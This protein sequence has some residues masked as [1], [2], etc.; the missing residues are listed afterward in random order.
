MAGRNTVFKNWP[1]MRRTVWSTTSGWLLVGLHLCLTFV[2]AFF[3]G[4]HGDSFTGRPPLESIVNG[5]GARLS[6]EAVCEC[7]LEA[8]INKRRVLG[9]T[10]G[11]PTQHPF[12][13]RS[14]R[15]TEGKRREE[16]SLVKK[17]LHIGCNGEMQPSVRGRRW[18]FLVA[19]A[20]LFGQ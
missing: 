9:C 19:D 20:C 18:R 11:V 7:A 3:Y 2:L 8:G 16:S 13:C 1:T 17:T 15:I 10:C 12:R 4:F 14:W 6:A 5:M